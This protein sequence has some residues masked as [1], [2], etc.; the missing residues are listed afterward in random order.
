[1]KNKFVNKF[2]EF[3]DFKGFYLFTACFIRK[4][5]DLVKDKK[6]SINSGQKF[7]DHFTQQAVA[8]IQNYKTITFLRSQFATIEIFILFLNLIQYD[9]ERQ[10]NQA[11]K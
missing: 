3:L 8:Q 10:L 1:M 4:I 6:I 9:A 7:L 11:K 2:I 5:N